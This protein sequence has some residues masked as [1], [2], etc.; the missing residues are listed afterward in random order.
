MA[1]AGSAPRGASL[2][3]ATRRDLTQ[4]LGG[5]R[6]AKL[7]MEAANVFGTRVVNVVQSRE[8]G[9][10]GLDKR[11]KGVVAVAH[12]P[13]MVGGSGPRAAVMGMLP[14]GA[15]TDSEVQSFVKSLLAH[16]R[17]DFGK[18]TK[19]AIASVERESEATHAI[20]SVR[21]KKVLQRIRFQCRCQC[22]S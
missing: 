13:V 21:G 15:D 5:A 4:R 6:G 18:P 19:G 17:I 1:L 2:D 3:A 22:C 7:S 20:K 10:G 16:D 14:H 8:V 12:E 11:L 9:L